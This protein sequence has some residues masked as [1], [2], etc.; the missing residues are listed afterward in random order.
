MFAAAVG[1]SCDPV[2]RWASTAYLYPLRPTAWLL[3][4]LRDGQGK[5]PPANAPAKYFPMWGHGW[6]QETADLS[7]VA[8]DEL[9]ARDAAGKLSAGDRRAIDQL[10]IADLASPIHTAGQYYLREDLGT[11]LAAGRLPPDE[12]AQVYAAALQFHLS[13]GPVVW[14]W[15]EVPLWI[16]RPCDLPIGR[17]DRWTVVGR[18]RAIKVDGNLVERP[19][20]GRYLAPNDLAFSIAPYRFFSDGEHAD[21]V[22]SDRIPWTMLGTHRID[23]ELQ[24]DVR[25]GPQGTVDSRLIHSELQVLHASFTE[26]E[27]PAVVKL[28]RL[29]RDPS[30]EAGHYLPASALDTVARHA[31]AAASHLARAEL[32]RRDRLSEL[33]FDRSRRL[34][35]DLLAVQAD[36]LRP[37]H[38]AYGDHIEWLHGQRR[39]PDAQWREY[40]RH[41]LGFYV[42]TRPTVNEGDPLPFDYVQLARRGNSTDR[43]YTGSQ[44]RTHVAFPDAVPGPIELAPL[45][46]GV[47]FDGDEYP[48]P[49]SVAIGP[50][51]PGTYSMHVWITDYDLTWT[52]HPADLTIPTEFDMGTVPFTVVPKSVAVVSAVVD[53]ALAGPIA[54]CIRADDL[55]RW[56][57]GSLTGRIGFRRPPPVDV[58]F[59]VVLAANGREWPV[60]DLAAAAGDA[61]GY[62]S[63]EVNVR[64]FGPRPPGGLTV[65]LVAD[66]SVAKRSPSLSR[67]WQGEVTLRHVHVR[68]QSE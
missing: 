52:D 36:R 43:R 15:N 53:P 7:R 42:R 17:S 3:R 63:A 20:V 2:E 66:A 54:D 24:I 8:L 22:G 55:L 39:L 67:Y 40:G 32:I 58:A 65:K 26:R 45:Q 61:V 48:Q 28:V 68:G 46:G 1:V 5:P 16:T 25:V 47:S 9:T 34:V 44:S 10:A 23:V 51:K 4:D 31:T 35:D 12:Q 59:H 50:A 41:Q 19:A 62:G 64:D 33:T 6:V 49:T 21:A 57:D 56:D 13:A 18:Y 37:W 30:H 27:P 14:Q 60:G 38:P 11:R 29:W